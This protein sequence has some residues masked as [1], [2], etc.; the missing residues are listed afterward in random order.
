MSPFGPFLFVF[1]HFLDIFMELSF[2]LL[3]PLSNDNYLKAT[4]CIKSLPKFFGI[5]YSDFN[6][7]KF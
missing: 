5:D 1:Y 4:K 7:L 2:V 3:L 6:G